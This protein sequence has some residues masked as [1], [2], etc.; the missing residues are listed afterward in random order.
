MSSTLSEQINDIGI[1][2]VQAPKHFRVIKR[3]GDVAEFD[4]AKISVA[5]TKAFLAV[6]GDNAATSSRL[7]EHSSSSMIRI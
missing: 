5:V 7:R 3:G 6:E 1:E 4:T 2:D